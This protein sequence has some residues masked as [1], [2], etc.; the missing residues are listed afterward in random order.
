[1]VRQIDSDEIIVDLLEDEHRITAAGAVGVEL[2]MVQP[3]LLIR[4]ER[5]A[6]PMPGRLEPGHL[7]MP[8]RQVCQELIEVSARVRHAVDRVQQ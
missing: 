4:L 5:S 3:E 8:F 7:D 6:P 2:R 1:M